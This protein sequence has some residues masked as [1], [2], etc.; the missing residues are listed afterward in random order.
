MLLDQ[1]LYNS[2][3]QGN[4]KRLRLVGY[5]TMERKH[6]LAAEL[7][8][9]SFEIYRNH[10]GIGNNR[11]ETYMPRDAIILE[12]AE[13][14]NWSDDR[15]ADE[16]EVERDTVPEWR[17]KIIRAKLIVDAANPA[18]S[19][20]RSVQFSIQ[21]ALDKG[22]TNSKDIEGLVSHICYRASDMS[23]MLEFRGES[24]SSYSDVLRQES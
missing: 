22:I 21:D 5:F 3:V 10:L 24:L 18:E 16:L 2:A 7:F 17:K 13:S 4:I 19:F 12:Q 11:F 9:Y 20:K 23:V 8:S 14:E 6:L 15:I 1:K